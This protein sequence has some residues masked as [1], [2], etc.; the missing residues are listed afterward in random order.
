L[1][2]S[3]ANFLSPV[4][5]VGLFSAR[6]PPA[7]DARSDSKEVWEQGS[8]SECP[9]R[10]LAE[11]RPKRRCVLM[12][13]LIG[14]DPH[15]ASVALAVLDE[16]LGG[17]VER[18]TFPQNRAGLRALERWAKRFPERRWAVENA[19]GLGRHLAVRLA[20]AGESVVDVPPK[21]SARVRVLSSGNARKNDGLDA[22][23]TALA[24]SHNE[25]LAT[26]DPEVGSEA[27]RL[28]SERREDLV[29]ERTRALNRLHGL[30][31][32]LLPGG[33]TGTLSAHR[34]ARI[35]RGI[36]PQGASARLRRRLASE[37]LRDVRTLDRKIADLNGRIEAEVE[38]TGT[39]L[40]EIFG[41]GPILAAKII[42]TVGN[43]GRF[44]TKAHFASYA[45][46]APVEASSGEVVRHRLSLAG[47]RHLNNALHMVATCQARSDARGG[48]YY[49]KKIAEGKS[50]KEA[51]RCL[52][53]RI[54]DAVFKSLMADSRTPSRSA[55]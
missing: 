36:R 11:V 20:A 19:S 46:T 21:L 52:K 54:S 34:A 31:R 47:N 49:R 17:F 53:R 55:A 14:V 15:K 27:L 3:L 50:R 24:A 51:L 48:A 7:P 6:V 37:I 13:V 5:W 44:P 26:V 28:L 4:R 43:V 18:A 29:A 32:D 22:L 25:R 23:A 41:I 8:K 2:G 16:A 33:A 9:S 45:G 38:L 1:Q 10:R 42:G 40:T 30:L 35:L 39:T 12:K